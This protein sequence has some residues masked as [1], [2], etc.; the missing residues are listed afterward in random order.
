MADKKKKGKLAKVMQAAKT[1]GKVV[2][3]PIWGTYKIGKGAWHMSANAY[4]KVDTFVQTSFWNV[5]NGQKMNETMF[6]FDIDNTKFTPRMIKKINEALSAGAVVTFESAHGQSVVQDFVKNLQLD[7]IQQDGKTPSPKVFLVCENGASIITSQTGTFDKNDK[8]GGIDLRA[9]QRDPVTGEVKEIDGHVLMGVAKKPSKWLSS[10]TRAL[11]E[12]SEKHKDA[13]IKYDAA[14][15]EIEITG[16]SRQDQIYH[17]LEILKS[18]MWLDMETP[19]IGSAI[20]AGKFIDE[21]GISFTDQGV[22][23]RPMDRSMPN[24]ERTI[25]DFVG[26]KG[27]VNV[28]RQVASTNQINVNI[29]LK[30]VVGM[31]QKEDGSFYTIEE[32]KE[33]GVLQQICDQLINFD[34]DMITV[35]PATNNGTYISRY[36][37]G[38]HQSLDNLHDNAER[39]SERV[40]NELQK[41]LVGHFTPVRVR[42]ALFEAM[43][44][45]YDV[46]QLTKLP[47]ITSYSDYQAAIASGNQEVIDKFQNQIIWQRNTCANVMQ[48]LR[49][50][51]DKFDDTPKKKGRI[52]SFL[53]SVAGKETLPAPV[54]ASKRDFL[55]K[56]S[57]ILGNIEEFSQQLVSIADPKIRA[58]ESENFS[59][60]LLGFEKEIKNGLTQEEAFNKIQAYI[61]SRDLSSIIAS[62]NSD[63]NEDAD[64]ASN[65]D[66]NNSS[67]NED[68]TNNDGNNDENNEDNEYIQQEILRQNIQANKDILKGID[69]KYTVGGKLDVTARDND[70]AYIYFQNINQKLE[71]NLHDRQVANGIIEHPAPGSAIVEREIQDGLYYSAANTNVMLY[72]DRAEKEA[73]A[74]GTTPELLEPYDITEDIANNQYYQQSQYQTLTGLKNVSLREFRGDTKVHN[75]FSKTNS[76]M[77]QSVKDSLLPETVADNNYNLIADIVKD[78]V[79]EHNQS[80][81]AIVAAK[82]NAKPDKKP[83]PKPEP[84]VAPEYERDPLFT[85]VCIK[86]SLDAYRRRRNFMA[87][88]MTNTQVYMKSKGLEGSVEYQILSEVT[89]KW[90]AVVGAEGLSTISK[91]ADRDKEL[92]QMNK[93]WAEIEEK[94][95]DNPEA[96]KLAQELYT[97]CMLQSENLTLQYQ[98]EKPNS[99]VVGLTSQAKMDFISKKSRLDAQN[100]Q[101]EQILNG[102]AST[103]FKAEIASNN[104]RL[105]QSKDSRKQVAR[106]STYRKNAAKTERV[107][108]TR[109]EARLKEV[110]EGLK[111]KEEILKTREAEKK[112]EEEKKVEQPKAQPKKKRSRQT[113]LDD[114]EQKRIEDFIPQDDK[115][116]NTEKQEYVFDPETAQEAKGIKQ[117]AMRRSIACMIEAQGHITKEQGQSFDAIKLQKLKAVTTNDL[118]HT[119]RNGKF[120]QYVKPEDMQMVDSTIKII[121][122]SC[123]N[124]YAASAGIE[125]RYPAEKVPD[126]LKPTIARILRGREEDHLTPTEEAIR[127]CVQPMMDMAADARKKAEQKQQED[128]AAQEVAKKAAEEAA[129]KQHEAPDATKQENA[130]SL[131]ADGPSLGMGKV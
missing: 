110:R 35:D 46:P 71:A 8:V 66:E 32:A 128:L 44:P 22:V 93:L 75:V 5:P 118:A 63:T 77:Q 115:P 40:N 78:K 25:C 73:Q 19:R 30:D 57:T 7:P 107:A 108:A 55:D 43:L 26:L 42:N 104:Y 20:P 4:K 99:K 72:N 15:Q 14:R 83:E 129:K 21:Y 82:V 37:F 67:H 10:S 17:A 59:G 124:L 56:Q 18:T 119:L 45:A 33:Q 60:F 36:R 95:A 121:S 69:N 125:F 112:S 122:H 49:N 85:K 113:T 16:G 41:R 96:I 38:N 123:F 27:H 9:P 2:T 126:E 3:S 47:Y 34:V 102:K 81:E 105:K 48:F 80:L 79:E 61:D 88:T 68:D 29:P 86:P 127:T 28:H 109:R 117:E 76:A 50:V 130:D 74:N 39:Y 114:P 1:T 52:S 23:I 11:K 24:A 91:A 64:T 54:A 13:G 31:L 98:A 106:G 62:T 120:I 6:V 87:Q 103:V 89:A 111:K 53:Y 70:P 97:S 131:D 94:Y 84:V 101:T 92:E 65:D 90:I 100:K 58:D 116:A 51:P 12:Y